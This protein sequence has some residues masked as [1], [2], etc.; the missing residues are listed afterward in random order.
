MAMISLLGEQVDPKARTR[1]LDEQV[2]WM[3]RI[4]GLGEQ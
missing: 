3:A 1:T 4:R 2:S